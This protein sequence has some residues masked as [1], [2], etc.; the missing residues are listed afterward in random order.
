M[1]SGNSE[2]SEATS[3]KV[4]VKLCEPQSQGSHENRV[5]FEQGCSDVFSSYSGLNIDDPIDTC[6]R[7]RSRQQV[8]AGVQP[9][10]NSRFMISC[11]QALTFQWN[12]AGCKLV[13]DGV[14]S[15][16]GV[17][18]LTQLL[19]LARVGM[20]PFVGR[21]GASHHGP[22]LHSESGN[23]HVRVQIFVH[24]KRWYSIGIGCGSSR[25]GVKSSVVG[26]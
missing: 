8:C 5:G 10:L 20:V 22:T 1:R 26:I 16:E 11:A 7:G 2:P 9:S 15:R 3:L 13:R 4:F 14:G 6:S 18:A 19:T 24:Y 23:R 17:W 25:S 21:V 12:V